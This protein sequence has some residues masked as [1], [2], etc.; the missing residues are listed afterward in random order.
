MKGSSSG[1]SSKGRRQYQHYGTDRSGGRQ[2]RSDIELS[3]AGG[4]RRPRGQMEIS[5]MD[6]DT[7]N[8]PDAGAGADSRFRY[9][10]NASESKDSQESILRQ[11]QD[12]SAAA[13]KGGKTAPS[14]ARHNSGGIVRTDVV[15]I[16]YEADLEEGYLA[17]QK[18]PKDLQKV[19]Q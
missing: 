3:R 18:L 11:R 10:N 12:V 6:L 8:D 5:F 13:N 16:Y 15:T 7:V 9:S 2:V 1:S 4:S 14:S 17:G 19:W